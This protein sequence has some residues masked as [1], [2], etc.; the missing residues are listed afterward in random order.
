MALAERLK[1]AQATYKSETLVC[2]LMSVTLSQKLS[3]EDVDYLLKV[4]NARPGDEHHMPN[5]RLAFALREEGFDISVSA[6]DRHR[7]GNCSCGRRA[8]G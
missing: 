3:E 6:V 7:R 8:N 2:K 5:T 1:S 4:I